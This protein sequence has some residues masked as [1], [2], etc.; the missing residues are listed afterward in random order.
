VS[1][2][3]SG[4]LH[5]HFSVT[6]QFN[7]LLCFKFQGHDTTAVGMSWAMYLLGSHPEVQVVFIYY[8]WDWKIE[9][10][11]ITYYVIF[12]R[13]MFLFCLSQMNVVYQEPERMIEGCKA[14][15]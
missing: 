7:Y 4:G 3:T 11:G 1:I 14:R 5:H 10:V 13:P 6:V 15:F 12:G 2:N 9:F 8:I